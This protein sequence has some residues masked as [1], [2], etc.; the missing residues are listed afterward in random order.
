MLLE[1]VN[2]WYYA[3]INLWTR[4][5]ASDS[6]WSGWL[7]SVAQNNS[8]TI[9]C[10]QDHHIQS[11]LFFFGQSQFCSWCCTLHTRYLSH[12]SLLTVPQFPALLLLQ[13]WLCHS[14]S[15]S[16]TSSVCLSML[17][18]FTGFACWKA[19]CGVSWRSL[20]SKCERLSSSSC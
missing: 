8:E 11:M 9:F 2:D 10:S 19:V 18:F 1:G 13:F 7:A 12:L 16:S 20:P 17:S 3:G 15:S 5:N 4:T 14:S 6:L